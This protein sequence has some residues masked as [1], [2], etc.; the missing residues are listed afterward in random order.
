MAIKDTLFCA[1]ILWFVV[2]L[3][4]ILLDTKV[5]LENKMR[6]ISFIV[7][8]ILVTILRNNGIYVIS[9]SL[10]VLILF[11]IKN[12]VGIKNIISLGILPLV[13]FLLLSNLLIFATDAS[14]TT[15]KEMLSI[16]FQQTA[17]YLSEYEKE[18]T[19]EEEQALEGVFMDVSLLKEQY[20]PNISD[21]I[22]NLYREEATQEEIME[23]AK[24]WISMGLRH[25]GIY[26][27]AFLNH[28]YGWFDPGS[29]NWIRYQGRM[30]IFTTP[31]YLGTPD[32]ALYYV[33]NFLNRLPVIG[34]LENVGIF[35]WGMLVASCYLF[36]KKKKRLLIAFT[37]LYVSLLVCIASPAFWLHPR[38]AF[39]IILCMP[40]LWIHMRIVTE[41]TE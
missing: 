33:Y 10:F 21:P 25:P 19:K 9:I 27:E 38:Y 37:P 23:Y 1:A 14:K 30:S 41:E 4:G 34:L 35:V 12:K 36:Y 13:G 28:S 2:E 26:V 20:D 17:R 22:K 18:I 11:L 32:K 31:E 6:V 16:P 3:V 5:F 8:A 39:P 40:F 24:A 29:N 7:S 15:S